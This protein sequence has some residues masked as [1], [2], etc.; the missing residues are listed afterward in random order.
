MFINWKMLVM[1]YSSIDFYKPLE[2]NRKLFINR[3]VKKKNVTN[4]YFAVFVLTK[5]LALALLYFY[6]F[7][8]KHE[9]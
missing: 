2:W 9:P 4:F 8:P 5:Y 1:F 3:F 7:N 6:I